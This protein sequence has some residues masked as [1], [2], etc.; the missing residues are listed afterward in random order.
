MDLFSYLLAGNSSG[1]GKIQYDVMPTPD[2]TTLGKIIQYVGET[3]ETYTNG[4]FYIGISDNEEN[5]TYSWQQIDV[6]PTND[7]KISFNTINFGGSSI[8]DLWNKEPGIY[9]VN[10]LSGQGQWYTDRSKNTRANFP[11]IYLLFLSQK[12]GENAPNVN[13]KIGFVSGYSYT[14]TKKKLIIYNIYH[15]TSDTLNYDANTSSILYNNLEVLTT[16]S[17]EITGTKTFLDVPRTSYD[18]SSNND[19]AR[20]KYVD[21]RP[22]Y[23]AGYDA[24][25]T[26][27]L[28][29]VNGTLTWVDE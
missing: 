26:Q 7:F 23:Y 5:P 27:V 2:E 29:N 21:D 19:L 3:N 24:T 20:K 22:K 28:K 13:T 8:L 6:Q 14:D 10:Y 12:I 1:G 4:Y 15:T 17:Q 9:L 11:M 16:T 25:K 18:P